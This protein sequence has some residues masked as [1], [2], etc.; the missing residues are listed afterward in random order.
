MSKRRFGP[1]AV[2]QSSQSR[3][4]Y[5]TRKKFWMRFISP[6]GWILRLTGLKDC[7]S[8]SSPAERI[9]RTIVE[10]NQQ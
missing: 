3:I 1:V 10:R 9:C 5:R 6:P 4:S 7:N 8:P 2:F